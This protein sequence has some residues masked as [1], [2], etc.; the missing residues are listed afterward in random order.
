MKLVY[1][2]HYDGNECK[3]ITPTFNKNELIAVEEETWNCVCEKCERNCSLGKCWG[4]LGTET[5][6]KIRRI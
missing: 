2:C 3:T 1:I 4:L 5:D 6:G